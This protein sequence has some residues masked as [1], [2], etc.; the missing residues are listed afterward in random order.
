MKLPDSEQQER[1]RTISML[2]MVALGF[3]MLLLI[4]A[5][6]HSP[7]LSLNTEPVYPISDIW[8]ITCQDQTF[9]STLPTQIPAKAG[10]IIRCTLT[11]Q[12]PDFLCN[13]ILFYTFHQSVNVYLD[14]KLLHTYGPNLDMPFHMPPTS[15][16]QFLRLPDGWVGQELC[17]ELTGV[18][19]NYSGRID[20]V[21]IGTK[22]AFSFMILKRATPNLIICIPIFIF[23][24]I[25]IFSG[26][27]TRHKN[28]ARRMFSLGLFSVIASCWILC[29]SQMTQLLFTKPLGNSLG[30][31]CFGLIPV[32]LLRFFLTYED[33]CDLFLMKLLY[34]LSIVNYI[35]IQILQVTG[36]ANY[37]ESIAGTHVLLL[38]TTLLCLY[39]YFYKKRYHLPIIDSSIFHAI[40]TFAAF[41]LIDLLHLYLVPHVSSAVAYTKIGL[42]FFIVILACHSLLTA[43]KERSRMIEQK[44][45]ENLAYTDI[46]TGLKN[47]TAFEQKLDYYRHKAPSAKPLLLIA[48]INYLKQIND[49]KGHSC[50]D[51]AIV[52]TGQCLEKSF[53]KFGI[54]YRIGGDEFCMIA[55]HI[56]DEALESCICKFRQ[57]LET[58]VTEI[59]FPL[60]VAIGYQRAEQQSI[61]QSMIDADRAMYE[62]KAKMKESS[63]TQIID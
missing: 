46:L 3:I 7:N 62:I 58:A 19:D 36:I 44:T 29:E 32:L 17:I 41:A 53:L 31:L 55:E 13:S 61:D 42:V 23:G 35:A 16:W 9:H 40:F 5:S 52:F 30:F 37:I 24:L 14:G 20:T 43:S 6:M 33:F 27:L 12:E 49:T 39:T 28:S 38:F 10:D 59:G 63:F 45:L 54:A 48:D 34:R 25:L 4:N 8:E 26:M 22:N 18:Y 56:S 47:R 60:E 57:L 11:L 2:S 51:S 1:F 15:G 21:W 50:G